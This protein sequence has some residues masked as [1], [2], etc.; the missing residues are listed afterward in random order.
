MRLQD[1]VALVTGGGRGIGAAIARR[2]AQEG[3]DVCLVSRTEAELEAQ[4]QWIA[5]QTGRAALPVVCDVSNP[6]DVERA[7]AVAEERFGRI[8]ILVNAAGISVAA[9]STDLSF[10]RW[11]ACLNINLD[12]TFLF[13]QAV[14]RGMIGRGQGGKVINI[15][16]VVA[17]AGIPERATY[18]ASKGGVRQLTQALAVE[19]AKHNIQVNAISPGFIMTE[20]VRDYIQRGIHKPEKLVARIP[21]GRM[22]QPDDIAGPAVFLASSDSDYVTGTILI[23]DGG[24]LA[25]GYV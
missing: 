11:K 7:V 17:H 16:S 1:K 20:I 19:W 5:S 8:D 14:G 6:A 24:F 3:A 21:A 13:C 18:A 15:T 22:G 25:N 12:G 2:F 10:D 23:V 4:A 9:P